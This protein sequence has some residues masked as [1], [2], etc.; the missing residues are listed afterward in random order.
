MLSSASRRCTGALRYH[1]SLNAVQNNLLINP[2]GA[3]SGTDG[4]WWGL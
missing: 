2:D 3:R 4:S 1:S